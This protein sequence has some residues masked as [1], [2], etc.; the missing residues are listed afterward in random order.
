MKRLVL[1]PALLLGGCSLAPKDVRPALPVPERFPQGAAYA[2]QPEAMPAEIS[3]QAVFRDARLQ[4]LIGQALENNRDLRIAAANIEQARANYRVQRA[5]LLPEVQGSAGATVT[6]GD[7][8]AGRARSSYGAEI[9]IT[10]F[11]IDLFGRLR[12]MSDAAR[13]DYLATES[14]ARATRLVLIGDLA[15]A[16]LDHATDASLLAIAERTMA[17]AERTLALTR[18]RFEGGIAPRSDVRQAETILAQARSD[19]AATRTL[20]AQDVN[21]I[22]LL[23]GGPV[24][25]ALLPGSIEDVREGVAA[26]PAG[27]DSRI[28]LA[29]PDVMQAEYRLRAANAR[30]GAARAALFPRISLSAIAGF[31]STALDQLF[32]KR[33]YGHEASPELSQTLFAGGGVLAGIRQAKAARSGALAEYEQAIQVA[34]RE[35]ADVLARAGTIEEQEA[36]DRDRVAAAEDAAGLVEARYRNGVVPYLDLLDAQR[37]LYVA[38]RSLATTLRARAATR[39]ALFRVLGGDLRGEAGDAGRS[40][41]P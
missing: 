26:L 35:T 17:S 2:P 14:A 8:N 19:L 41:T 37:S 30:I 7:G 11:E 18:A 9:G 10:G 32:D 39:V 15:T 31:A 4:A 29:R 25:P 12:S 27:M 34:F 24:D 20:V 21:L 33:N 5:Q 3:W 40:A 22:Q 38:Q 23:V 13:Q 6:G 36:A 28:L 1:I 16:W